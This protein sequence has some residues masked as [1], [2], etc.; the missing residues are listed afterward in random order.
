MKNNKTMIIILIVSLIFI[1]TIGIVVVL[2]LPKNKNDEPMAVI[3]NINN[4]K[5]NEEV[6]QTNVVKDE[7]IKDEITVQVAKGEIA[8]QRSVYTDENNRKAV[9]P[10]GYSVVKDA[11]TINNG[12]VIS[13]VENDDMNNSLGGNQFVWVPVTTPI[14]DVSGKTTDSQINNELQKQ[15]D[16]GLYPMAIRKADGNY[17]GVIYDFASVRE[18]TVIKITPV[19]HG[20]EATKKEPSKI[21]TDSGETTYQEDFNELIKRVRN[22]NGFWIA[23]YETSV[24]ETGKAQSKKNQNVTTGISWY[25]MYNYEKTLQSGK[26]TS[27]MIWGSQ[28]DQVMIWLRGVRN[29]NTKDRQYYIVNS[30]NMGN[31]LNT[32]IKEERANRIETVK[33]SG[34]AVRY[35]SG[36]VKQSLVRNI[37]DMAGNVWEWTMEANFT[38]SRTVRGGDCSYDGVTYPVTARFSFQADYSGEKIE[39]IGSRMTIY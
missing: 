13:D 29:Y 38:S 30:S 15:A 19:T 27:N 28:W 32:E 14:L 31:Y 26:T 11:E 24:D 7:F 20:A 2:A 25:Q 18:N 8:K 37:Y 12:L 39:N 23:R 16:Q 22:D 4:D 6:V 10:Q 21:A 36:T 35:K 1:V 17:E 9:I 34:E 33:K 3:N 5:K